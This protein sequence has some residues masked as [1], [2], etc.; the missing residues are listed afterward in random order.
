MP[1]QLFPFPTGSELDSPEAGQ[2]FEITRRMI[3]TP[4]FFA[5]ATD[6]GPIGVPDGSWGIWLNTT[7][8]VLKLWVNQGGV[9]KSTTLT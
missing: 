2:W 3:N 4:P 5:Q 8:G 9:L 1:Q 6:P 7:S